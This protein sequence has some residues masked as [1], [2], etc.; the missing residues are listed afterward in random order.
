MCYIDDKK[1]GMKSMVNTVGSLQEFVP[2]DSMQ[3]T[4]SWTGSKFLNTAEK[5]FITCKFDELCIS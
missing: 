5:E 1:L 2:F 4:E 3:F